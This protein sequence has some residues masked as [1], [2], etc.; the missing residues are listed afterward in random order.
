VAQCANN[1][2]PV[3]V[4]FVILVVIV[5]IVVVV[6]VIVVV[7][8]AVVAVVAVDVDVDVVAGADIPLFRPS[9]RSFLR[10]LSDRVRSRL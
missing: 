5:V 1:I 9:V 8:V 2:P 4:I 6:V 10:F 3:L 7:V